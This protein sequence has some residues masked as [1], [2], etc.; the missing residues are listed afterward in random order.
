[1]RTEGIV[2]VGSAPPKPAGAPGALSAMITAKAPA[3]CAFFTFT[4][5]VQVP[6]SI[7]AIFPA[8]AGVTETQP[9][10]ES[11]TRL[12][13][14]PGLERGAPKPA[15]PIGLDPAIAAGAFTV[16]RGVP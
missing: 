13:V 1:M 11:Y 6:R 7:M 10:L 2:I 15:V 3:F 8:T 16:T 14:M 9:R 12:L 5:K 4:T